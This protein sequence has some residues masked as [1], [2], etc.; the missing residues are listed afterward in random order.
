[1]KRHPIVL[2]I[3]LSACWAASTAMAGAPTPLTTV[4]V[5]S[6]LN[7][8]IFATAAPGDFDR[9]FIVEKRGVIK[10][11]NLD[12]GVVN[13][14]AFL[15]IDALI[16]GG[17][18]NNDERG[19]LGMAFHPD[20][21][22][23]GAFYV[24]YT[25][26]IDDTVVARYTVS[27]N[28]DVADSGSAQTVITYDQPQSNHNG[29]WIGFSPLDGY[30]YIGSGDG[31]G[32]G[33]DDA[34]HTPGV[35]NGQDITNNLLGKML[36]IDVDGD[37]FPADATRNYAIPVNNPFVAPHIGDDEI[38]A[39]GL[40]NPW[41]NAFDRDNGDLYIADVGQNAWEEI[42]WQ[43]G[44]SRG[45]QNYGWR[46]REGKHNFNTTGDCTQLPFTEP[47]Y[48]YS[49]ASGCSITGGYPYRGCAIAD[50][51]GTYF[52]ADYCSNSI[53]SF[54]Y[55]PF[56]LPPTAD[57]RTS[58]LAPGGGLSISSIVSF[59]E[60]AYGEM[61]IVE[62]CGSS[63]GEIYK[64]VAAVAP[65]N[66]CN[67][68][69]TEDFCDLVDGSSPDTNTNGVPDECEQ[70]AMTAVQS[71]AVHCD[72][73]DPINFPNCPA[74]P[75]YRWCL[76]VSDPAPRS[77]GGLP[78]P[79]SDTRIEPRFYN[80]P[81]AAHVFDIQVDGPPPGTVFVEASCSDGSTP[82][83]DSV[84][85]NGTTVTAAFQ[86]PLPNT[87]C[88]TLTVSGGAVGVR[89]VWLLAGDVNGSTRVNA[90]D[91]NIV[92]GKVTTWSPPLAGDD[93]FHDVNMSGR[94]N[95]TDKNLVKGNINDAI[96]LSCP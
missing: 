66:D 30:L 72:P 33:D 50:L 39:F 42:D 27:A 58:E 80:V 44:S 59:G 17:N 10:I 26:S 12:T 78:D 25:N 2:A 57:N 18:S 32:G 65:G 23:N 3:A 38:W 5:A 49:H 21:G 64:I 83:A 34:G 37:D 28:P 94:I 9:L 48:E 16:L 82:T 79:R 54:E 96:D 85:V 93:F 60:D 35:G 14:T 13:G 81:G 69:G 75:V 20:Y 40:R 46:C 4:R 8:P 52:F 88:C 76:N 90:T 45:G 55:D 71:C 86:P 47:I 91:K 92:K 70:V 1:M 87:H 15:N 51:Q 6:G 63:C 77:G 41:R 95:A 61:Y 84:S 36:R 89:I 31:G 24:Y 67:S 7:R 74:D 11:L 62:Q 22:T 73:G 56:G 29:G 43:P 53:W 68:N 19:L